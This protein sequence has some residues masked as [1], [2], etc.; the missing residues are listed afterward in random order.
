[1]QGFIL[2]RSVRIPGLSRAFKGF[3]KK[4]PGLS[5]VFQTFP[6]ISMTFPLFSQGFS[7]AFQ[8]FPGLSRVFQDFPGLSR[9]FHGF[10]Q[11]FP[12]GTLTQ[13]VYLRDSPKM[14]P[15]SQCVIKFYLNRLNLQIIADNEKTVNCIAKALKQTYVF[16]L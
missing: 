11:N 9:V 12:G 10:F 16:Y 6:L 1:M 3:S 15:R 7:M 2:I 13:L 4:F 5:I 14:V 8:S